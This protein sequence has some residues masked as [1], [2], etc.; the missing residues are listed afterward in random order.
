MTSSRCLKA[1][2]NADSSS[3]LLCHYLACVLLP[4]GGSPL[5]TE[6]LSEDQEMQ[7]EVCGKQLDRSNAT[8]MCQICRELVEREEQRVEIK[9]HRIKRGCL[10]CDQ[11]FWAQGK[12]NRICPG[13]TEKNRNLADMDR[14]KLRMLESASKLEHEDSVIDVQAEVA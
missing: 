13:C 11:L 9:E 7:C 12:F 3:N 1:N 8:Q 6:V 10:R 2:S 4:P 14:Y 5:E